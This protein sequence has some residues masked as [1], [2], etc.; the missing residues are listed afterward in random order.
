M[1]TEDEMKDLAFKHYQEWMDFE[2]E[3]ESCLKWICGSMAT[4][5]GL[6]RTVSK[7]SPETAAELIRMIRIDIDDLEQSLKKPTVN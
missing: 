2:S 3:P 5:R 6:V 1:A 4:V 7:L